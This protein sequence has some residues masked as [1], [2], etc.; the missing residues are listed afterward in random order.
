M[1]CS[2][3]SVLEDIID[4]ECIIKLQNYLSVLNPNSRKLITVSKIKNALGITEK[5]ATE[6]LV[7]CRQAGVL[8]I[9]YAVR[10]PDCDILIKRI[11]DINISEATRLYCYKCGEEKNITKEDIVVL[12]SLEMDIP[13]FNKG[14]LDKGV[15]LTTELGPVAPCDMLTAISAVTELCTVA[16]TSIKLNMK[17]NEEDSIKCKKLIELD[18]SLKEIEDIIS[19]NSITIREIN[20]KKTSIMFLILF[21]V[22]TGLILLIFCYVDNSQLSYIL[23]VITSILAFLSDKIINRILCTDLEYIR[24]KQSKKY[25]NDL[26]SLHEEKKLIELCI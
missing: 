2:H 13:P 1:Y 6:I 3:L 11:D 23:S 25:E 22:Y 20:R 26:K 16:T 10:C 8:N 24:L 4:K 17:K 5:Q 19:K 12:F 7:K 21:T 15:D 14:Q 18:Y 9:A